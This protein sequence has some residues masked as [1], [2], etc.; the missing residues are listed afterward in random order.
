LVELG[1]LLSLSH[2]QLLGNNAFVSQCILSR[3]I[4]VQWDLLDLEMRCG[5]LGRCPNLCGG[6]CG[7]LRPRLCRRLRMK[8]GRLRTVGY[9]Y[10]V[11]HRIEKTETVLDRDC[12]PKV[13]RAYR[14]E[15]VGS[16]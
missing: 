16:Y 5:M 7:E 3:R 10:P 14:L 15:K 11:P 9:V 8:P 2:G 6:V 1:R 4:F 12:N 13:R